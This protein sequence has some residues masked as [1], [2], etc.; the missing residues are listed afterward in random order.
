M[1]PG[2]SRRTFLGASAAALAVSRTGLGAD[3]FHSVV[4]VVDQFVQR[5][6]P[7]GANGISARGNDKSMYARLF[8]VMVTIR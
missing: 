1:N 4:N 2:T 6:G 3:K 5:E 7:E 8:D